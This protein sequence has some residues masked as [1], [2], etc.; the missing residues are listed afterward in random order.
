MTPVLG[1]STA[2]AARSEAQDPAPEEKRGPAQRF[3]LGRRELRA[4]LL[5]GLCCLLVYNANRRVISAG[6]TF[7]ARY[8]PFAIWQHHTL[9]LD[10]IATLTAQG[11]GDTAFWMVPTRSGHTI[12][13]YPVVTPVLLAPLYLPAVGYLHLRGWNEARLDHVAKVMEK[14]AASLVAA[15]SAALLYL[16]LRRRAAAPIA[17]LLAL[18]YAFG[19]TT[20]MIGSQA[21]WQHGMAELLVV[22]ALLFLTA[23]CTT[24]RALAAGLLLG[25]IAAN[26]PPDALLAAALGVYGLFW[27]RRRAAPLVALIAAVAV[28]ASLVLLYNL[29]VAGHVGGGYGI[30]GRADFLHNDLLPGLAGLLFS[31]TRGLLIFSPFLLFLVLAWRYRLRSSSQR[32]DRAYRG[33]A[34][35]MSFGIILQLVLYAKADWRA[36]ISWGPRFLTDFLP[37]LVWMLVPVVAALRG[38]GRACFLLTVGIAIAIEAIGAFWY[39]G[40]TDSAIFAVAGGPQMQAAWQWKNAPFV[41]S[42]RQG[43]APAE[44][45][46]ETRGSFDAVEADGQEV[47]AIG[48]A[49][50]GHASPWQVAVA[51]DGREMVASDIFFKRPD[52]RASLNEASPAGWR[53]PL[54]TAGLAPG[55]HQLAAF[56]WASEHGERSYLG[57]RQLTVRAA[58]ADLDLDLGFRTAAAR[59]RAHQQEP[60]YWLTS[61][62]TAA[63]FREPRPE[64]NTFLTAFLLDLLDP[65]AVTSGLGENLQRARQHLT[66]QIEAG[67]LVRYHGLPDAPGVISEKGTLGCAITPDTDDTALVWRLAPSRDRRRLPAALATIRQYR[68]REGLYRTWLAPREAY[69]CLDPGSD[70]NPA[71]LAIQMHL[72]L[73]L[74][75]EQPPAA[76]ALCAA[77]RPV[78]AQDRV[79]VYYRKAP[80]VPILRLPD[81]QRAGC[82]LTLPESRMRTTVPGQE[83]WIS[84]ARLLARPRTASEIE[85]VLRQLARDDFAR[86]RKSPPLLYHNDLTATVPR[87]YWSE[88]AGYALWLRLYHEQAHL[89]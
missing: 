53:I 22:G 48:W 3:W 81:V 49:L 70:P 46:I 24:P 67:G 26:R 31:P 82:A 16:L 34:L 52:V 59:I 71:D 75:E 37:L 27:A 73:L 88:D 69:Q 43:L 68:T 2:L 15:L 5:L 6:D 19:T 84:A 17:L 21:L 57:K 18:A 33:L 47:V 58:D 28:P 80:L 76:R 39:T 10:P 60:G 65:L 74:A 87:Y 89:R 25:L 40:A 77:L 42:L 45:L 8:L 4:S 83:I 85:T 50:A 13:L 64:M 36:G 38:F 30:M 11:R 32:A 61:Y 35:A 78:I 56:S 41:A 55:E 14:L 51:V 29:G 1:V 23:P 72:L 20:W 44:L 63:S 62:T 54:D 79:W 66:A 12:S 86:V 7:P 9:L